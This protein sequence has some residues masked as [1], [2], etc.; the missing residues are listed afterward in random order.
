MKKMGLMVI[1]VALSLSM[2]AWAGSTSANTPTPTQ[3]QTAPAAK[4]KG[5]VAAQTPKML[6]DEVAKLKQEHQAAVN[7]LEEI[8]K[9]ANEEKASKTVAALD[10]MITRRKIGRASCRERVSERV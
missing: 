6:A 10:K 4:G 3:N 5:K 8:K 7:E 1:A 2:A 9:L